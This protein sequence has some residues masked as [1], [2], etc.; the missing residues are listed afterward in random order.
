MRNLN[1]WKK[2]KQSRSHLGTVRCLIRLIRSAY[3]V[4][5]TQ[6]VKFEG[7]TIYVTRTQKKWDMGDPSEDLTII[8]RSATVGVKAD[9]E[10]SVFARNQGII[11]RLL[12]EARK[13]YKQA[14]L[15]NLAIWTVD[16]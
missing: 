2:V 7:K 12:A 4:D 10:Y 11:H 14:D 3:R 15:G 1:S 9:D 13:E 5:Q 8:S 6:K 16:P